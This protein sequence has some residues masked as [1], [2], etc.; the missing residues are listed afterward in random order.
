VT[1]ST[2]DHQVG[3]EFALTI[4]QNVLDA[5]GAVLLPAGGKATGRITEAAQSAGS[6]QPAVIRFTVA[7][8]LFE[9]EPV[10]LTGDIVE[11]EIQGDSRTSGGR[12][13]AIIAGGAAAGALVGRVVGGDAR[14]AVVGA[15]AGAAAGTAYWLVTRD[16]HAELPAGSS[17]TF[18]LN[19]PVV[20]R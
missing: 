15:V 14:D 1:I 12:T 20:I 6:D 4:M 8:V 19:E 11:A 16:G 13:A 9:D 10:A 18:V 5:E 17:L 3:D 7:N 2:K